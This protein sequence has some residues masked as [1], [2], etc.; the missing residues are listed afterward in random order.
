MMRFHALLLALLSLA[1][2]G[3]LGCG[4]RVDVETRTD[5]YGED[6]EPSHSRSATLSSED[7]LERAERLVREGDHAGAIAIYR[8]IYRS[9]PSSD[10]KALALYEW[11]RAEGNLLNP[12]RDIDA[13][14]ARMELLLNEFPNA[15]VA[16]RAREELNRLRTFQ[17]QSG[18]PLD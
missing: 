7:D 1:L 11:A 14:I 4:N 12:D 18:R 2:V 9:A 17:G 13:A 15:A 16:F 6:G 5:P 3:T 10:D 8:K